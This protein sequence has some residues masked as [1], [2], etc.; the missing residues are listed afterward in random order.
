M[1]SAEQTSWRATTSSLTF[2]GAR[3]QDAVDGVADGALTSRR[4]C[5]SPPDIPRPLIEI[6]SRRAGVMVG[7]LAVSR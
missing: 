4:S 2:P 5:T 6:D 3:S 7:H 1:T